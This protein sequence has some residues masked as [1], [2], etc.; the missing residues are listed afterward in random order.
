MQV[1]ASGHQ[2]PKKVV[3]HISADSL[4]KDIKDMHNLVGTILRG[5]DSTSIRAKMSRDTALSM[6][7]E[8]YSKYPVVNRVRELIDA[9]KENMTP[10]FTRETKQQLSQEWSSFI[11]SFKTPSSI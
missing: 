4:V 9:F 2:M 8:R 1:G 11:E 7:E 5:M 10:E 3:S 6:L